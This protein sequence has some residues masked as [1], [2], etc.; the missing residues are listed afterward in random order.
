MRKI[1]SLLL[2]TLLAIAG[3]GCDSDDN[4]ESD[5]AKFVGHWV[6]TGVSDDDGDALATFAENF[7]SISLTNVDDGSFTL[8][9]D[10]KVGD[11]IVLPGTYSVNE[12]A[13][14]FTLVATTPLG[15]A[16]LNFTYAFDGDNTIVLTSDTTT[17]LLLNTLFD[18]VDLVGQA[19][20]TISRNT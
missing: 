20:I 4:E 17:A 13:D 7:D 14:R 6:L 18:G 19:V 16:S 10:P 11:N 9:V 12:S 5:A 3:V 15:P 8:T 1:S 2:I